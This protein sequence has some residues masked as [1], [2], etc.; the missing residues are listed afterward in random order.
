MLEPMGEE[1]PAG[2]AMPI[3]SHL[4]DGFMNQTRGKRSA[5]GYERVSQLS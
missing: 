5:A 2:A 1:E 3:G 4:S